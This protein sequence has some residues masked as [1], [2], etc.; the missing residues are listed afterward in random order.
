M[1]RLTYLIIALTLVLSLL[2][3][4]CSTFSPTKI[5]A[6][7]EETVN[8]A[9]NYSND[10]FK[11]IQHNLDLVTNLKAQLLKPQKDGKPLS[12]NDAIK[13]IESVTQSYES[14]SKRHAEIIKTFANKT[15]TIK[16]MLKSV[17]AQINYLNNR[18]NNYNYQ[19]INV[20]KTTSDPEIIRTRTKALNQAVS[21][22]ESQIKLWR[23]FA[24]LEQDINNEMDNIQV[25]L[26]DFLSMI[27]SSAIVFREGL[28]LMKL[29]RDINSALSLFTVDLPEIQR[30]TQQMENS[31]N[32]L[33]FLVNSLTTLSTTMSVK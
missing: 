19:L 13:D 8:N 14:L 22:V 33:D 16:D 17:D 3:T 24:N 11:E 28:N 26:N 4:S 23:Q 2:V 29:Q 18:I 12:L 20:S 6:A 7:T 9:E 30:L 25:Q 27:D 10:I 1:K 31:W 32:D 15:Q 21:Y 5:V